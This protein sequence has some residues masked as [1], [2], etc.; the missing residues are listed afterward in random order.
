MTRFCCSTRFCFLDLKNF[1]QNWLK[2][3]ITSLKLDSSFTN[4]KYNELKEFGLHF[5][6]S[7]LLKLQ[8]TEAGLF[9]Q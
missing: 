8:V 3:K 2:S 1:L 5:D 9:S 6:N 4:L 7:I